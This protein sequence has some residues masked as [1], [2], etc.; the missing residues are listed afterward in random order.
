MRKLITSVALKIVPRKG[1]LRSIAR[2]IY[3]RWSPPPKRDYICPLFTAEEQSA[4]A[5][6][7]RIG[8][9]GDLIL[10]RDMVDAGRKD[11]GYDFGPMFSSMRSY[12]SDCDLMT[13]VLEGPLPGDEGG[14]TVGNYG[15][16][17]P[18]QCGYPDEF[19]KAIKDAGVGFVTVA[20]NHLLDKG[21]QAMERTVA[22][23]EN[24]SF[25]Y[26][27]YGKQARTL[28]SVRGLKIAVLAFNYG[29][30]GQDERFFF[31]PGNEEMPHLIRPK[32]SK[33][34]AKCLQQVKEDFEWAKQ[35]NPHCILVYPHVGGQF[36]HSPDENQLHWFSIF[37]SLG[38]DV[39]LGCHPH[40]TQPVRFEGDT[41]CLYCP[42]NFV[43]NYFPYDGDASAMVEAYLDS[44]TGKPVAAAVVPILAYSRH[45]ELLRAE[46]MWRLAQSDS[47][48]WHDWL[49]LN[50]A[51]K[52][53]TSSM[54]GVALPVDQSQKRHYIWSD[55]Q[56]RRMP[57]DAVS[58]IPV[59]SD[60]NFL[61]RVF[62]KST[63][64]VFIGDSITE[65]TKNGGF[66]W[67]EPF[68]ASVPHKRVIRFAKG[69]ATSRTLPELFGTEIEKTQADLF[70]IAVGCN[71]IRYRDESVCA[72]TVDEYKK[73]IRRLV[74]VIRRNNPDSAVILIAPWWS[75]DT[76]DRYCR[77]DCATKHRLY[78]EYTAALIEEA[79]E[80]RCTFVNPNPTIWHKIR[81]GIQQQY[82]I[83]WI[84]PNAGDGIR[85]YSEAFA[86]ELQEL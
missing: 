22:T 41:L 55:N 43:N 15:D 13:G 37:R 62:D 83:D 9:I 76:Y 35:Q 54:L 32:K 24:N 10:L 18:L 5:S 21:R 20:N 57:Y 56:C 63:T 53:V 46:P 28:I 34:Y 17:R 36:R 8:F 19:L 58:N 1:P 29:F 45:N 2:R 73:N 60:S 47:L 72:M 50:D 3:A 38:A 81:S 25:P 79:D 68:M 80:D 71:D 16:G 49:R 82:L 70:C 7:V 44:S 11:G 31:E 30:N 69:G 48:S 74:S 6:A 59:N 51:H 75:D 66:G 27:G 84:H 26:V 64:A 39:I 33:Y 40:A 23:L 4:L 65:G 12:F 52:K 78:A 85:L 61:S 86:N 67:F 42:G 77:P 14:Y